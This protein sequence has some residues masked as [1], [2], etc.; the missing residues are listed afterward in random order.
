[1]AEA[2]KKLCETSGPTRKNN[3][4]KLTPKFKENY[5]R[6]GLCFKCR[7]KDHMIHDCHNK[8]NKHGNKANVASASP[9]INKNEVVTD[10]KINREAFLKVDGWVQEQNALILIDSEALKDFVSS[11]FVEQTN[12]IKDKNQSSQIELAN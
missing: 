9:Q 11:N 1:M 12:L 8:S 7:R 6:K 5:K 10:I 2:H 4:K 3:E